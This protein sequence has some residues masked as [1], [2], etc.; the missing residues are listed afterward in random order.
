MERTATASRP[1]TAFHTR[2]LERAVLCP[3]ASLNTTTL[4]DNCTNSPGSL[5]RTATG[6]P[7]VTFPLPLQS[8]RTSSVPW[9]TFVRTR[10]RRANPS[11]IS[12]CPSSSKHPPAPKTVLPD[13]DDIMYLVEFMS[14]CKRA[15]L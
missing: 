1:P 3:M 15:Y 7:E 5:M 6:P 14:I 2:R 12:N 4:K 10:P 9:S 8:Q 13:N 11:C